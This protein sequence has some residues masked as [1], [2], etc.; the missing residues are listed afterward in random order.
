MAVSHNLDEFAAEFRA[1]IA[2]VTSQ[3][4]LKNARWQF[5]LQPSTVR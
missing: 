1:T 2:Y 4:L 3:K 5:S